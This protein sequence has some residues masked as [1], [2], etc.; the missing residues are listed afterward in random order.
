[1]NQP[2]PPLGFP[3]DTFDLIYA[4]SVFTHLG[5]VGQLSWIRELRRIARPGG[6]VLITTHGSAPYY[7]RLLSPAQQ[8]G[9]HDG[10]LVIDASGPVGSNQFSAYHPET[11]VRVTLSEGFTV[12][13]YL[14]GGAFGNP[15]QPPPTP[16]TP[17]R[18][19]AARHDEPVAVHLAL[20]GDIFRVR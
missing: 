5:E 11:Y 12:V 16:R 18:P 14:E 15:Y 6:Y 10:Q 13:A 4:L 17:R 20:D 1:V 2:V 3:N 7:L 8:A 19:G 9:F